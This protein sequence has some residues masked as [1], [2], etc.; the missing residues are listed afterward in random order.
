MLIATILSLFLSL[1]LSALPEHGETTC[2][3]SVE[4]EAYVREPAGGL[5]KPVLQHGASQLCNTAAK[6]HK[7]N[8]GCH[9]AWCKGNE[10]R[11]Q[12]G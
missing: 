6:G 10:E 9:E 1:L 2:I 5:A 8:S 4:T 11:V 7:D 3:K 12:E